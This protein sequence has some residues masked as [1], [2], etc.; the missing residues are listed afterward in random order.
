ML[1]S[2]LHAVYIIP[3]FVYVVKVLFRVANVMRHLTRYRCEIYAHA[4]YTPAME[5]VWRE[6]H[7]C[8]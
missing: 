8:S 6:I 4:H 7:F 5:T 3:V 2:S 1:E